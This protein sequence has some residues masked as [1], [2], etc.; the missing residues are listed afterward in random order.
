MLYVSFVQMLST[1]T[2]RIGKE[3]KEFLN[4]KPGITQNNHLRCIKVFI[5]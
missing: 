5:Y 1:A 3:N 2:Y 4:L